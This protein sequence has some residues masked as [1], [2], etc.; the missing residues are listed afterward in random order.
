VVDAPAL[1]LAVPCRAR[2]PFELSAGAVL[3]TLDEQTADGDDVAGAWAMLARADGLSINP[4]QR[5]A[6][7]MGVGCS[8]ARYTKRYAAGRCRRTR[9]YW[10]SGHRGRF[11][12]E[13]SQRKR[14]RSAG[15]GGRVNK[16][17]LGP[18]MLRPLSQNLR[19]R[20]MEMIEDR[21][22]CGRSQISFRQ[23][24]CSLRAMAVLGA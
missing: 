14:K 16:S 2:R 17:E 19:E 15:A 13:Q 23:C 22:H 24:L 12:P 21:E 4:T 1:A 20:L 8:S 7:M 11:A 18:V 3:A 10:L 9:W 5:P 6:V